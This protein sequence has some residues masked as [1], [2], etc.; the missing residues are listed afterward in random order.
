M[1]AS[2]RADAPPDAVEQ[3][4]AVPGLQG[5]DRGAY[6][7]L[8]QIQRLCRTGDVL[9]FGDGHENAELFERHAAA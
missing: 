1:P 2:V 7:G 4:D 5:G 8:R 9:A 6:R 3:F